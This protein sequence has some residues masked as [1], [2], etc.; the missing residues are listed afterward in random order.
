MLSFQKFINVK[1]AYQVDI[2]QDYTT[3]IDDLVQ[4]SKIFT[5]KNPQKMKKFLSKNIENDE[6]LKNLFKVKFLDKP[7]QD[8]G[9]KKTNT[10]LGHYAGYD[11]LKQVNSPI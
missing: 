10:P 3:E 11:F 1:E 6:E 4:A 5:I 7:K 9:I 8:L 2:D